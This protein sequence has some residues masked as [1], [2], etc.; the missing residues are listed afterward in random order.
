MAHYQKLAMLGVAAI[1]LMVPSAFGE[2]IYEIDFATRT[3]AG[4]VPM[5]EWRTYNYLVD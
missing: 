5:S 1:S 4:V 2:V 3:S